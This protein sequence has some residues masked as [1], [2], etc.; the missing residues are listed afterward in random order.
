MPKSAIENEEFW[1]QQLEK[2]KSSGLSRAQYCGENSINYDRFSYWIKRLNQT[3]STFIP[4]K[5]QESKSNICP[6]A[7]CTLELRGHVIKIHDLS[8]LSCILDRM[9]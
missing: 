1:K 3:P 7:L 4:V 2:L 9:I 6:V 8:A 5:I